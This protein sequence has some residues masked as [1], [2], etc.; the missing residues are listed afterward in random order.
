MSLQCVLGFPGTAEET[1]SQSPTRS[2]A[3]WQ[4]TTEERLAARFAPGAA[5]CRAAADRV[6]LN[7]NSGDIPIQDYVNGAKTPALF[8]P[9]E[10]YRNFI[11]HMFDPE[12]EA[13]PTRQLIRAKWQAL[14]LPSEPENLLRG[15]AQRVLA[16]HEEDRR[17]SL[18]ASRAALAKGEKPNTEDEGRA[19]ALQAGCKLL[20]ESLVA[21]HGVVRS[22]GGGD[23][24]LR[25]LYEAVAPVAKVIIPGPGPGQEAGQEAALRRAERG[26]Q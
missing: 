21:A 6:S 10:L 11:P 22:N 16:F 5:A 17:R 2:K 15:E 4:W 13:S 24:F 19:Q 23:G 9:I 25:L 26:C 1:Q 14:N 20:Q 7:N 3:A 18:E 8:L 12:F